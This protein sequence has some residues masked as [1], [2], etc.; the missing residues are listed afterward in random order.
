MLSNSLIAPHEHESVH[1]YSDPKVGLEAIIAV[2][3]TFSGV[4]LGGCRMSTYS[5]SNKALEDVLKLSK[6][7][8]YKSLMADLDIGGGKSVIVAKKN[9]KKTPELL[10]AFASAVNSLGGRY[11]VSVDMGSDVEDMEILRKN[12][13]W[14]IGYSDKEGGAGDPG[15]YTAKGVLSSMK[16]YADEQWGQPS[17][18]G[19]K[20][21]V[22]GLGN[23]GFVLAQ[24]LINEEALLTASDI[25][26]QKAQSVKNLHP[27]RVEIIDPKKAHTA[28]CDIFSPC[29]LG[30]VFTE[31]TVLELRCKAIAGA[32]NNQ[33]SS[34][35]AGRKLHQR[36]ILYLPDFV[37]N[38]GGLIGVVL[39][40]LKKLSIEEVNKKVEQI[41][42]CTRT[43]IQ[44]AKKENRP[45]SEVAL[46][47]AKNR[48]KKTYSKTK[49]H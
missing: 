5:S 16:A 48:Y 3:T 41:G 45:T 21:C 28:R 10:R 22:S 24:M 43:I 26:I 11:I 7:M 40:G 42:Y 8:T 44:K 29:A 19:K 46:N 47:I 25:D 49:I 13:Q 2:H 36:D 12:C 37:V 4:S 33:L 38:S 9:M 23:V 31:E 6:H 14:V 35:G 20:I 17:L 1:F 39:R 34:S 18:K 15:I 30:E 27:D 32:A